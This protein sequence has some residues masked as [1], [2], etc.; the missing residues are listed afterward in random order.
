MLPMIPLEFDEVMAMNQHMKKAMSRG[1][2]FW[3]V[4]WKGGEPKK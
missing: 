1:G 3:Y 2:K 4:F